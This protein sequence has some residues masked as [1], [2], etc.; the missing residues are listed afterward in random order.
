M[1]PD[2]RVT[3]PGVNTVRCKN[4]WARLCELND[5]GLSIH[6]SSLQAT[7]C[8]QFH[9]SLVCYRCGH[10][11]VMHSPPNLTKSA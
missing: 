6:R 8:G 7:V 1:I 4:C 11:N 10:L 9:A 3:K 2:R 5:N